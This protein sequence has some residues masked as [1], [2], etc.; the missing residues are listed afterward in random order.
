MN[1]NTLLSL[2]IF[3]SIIYAVYLT[4]LNTDP[5][6]GIYVTDNDHGDFYVTALHDLGWGWHNGIQH[7]D[8]IVLIDGE[9]PEHNHI[10]TTH[11]R[12]EQVKTLT[13]NQNGTDMT[14]QIDYSS[15]LA[16]QGIIYFLIPFLYFLMS[17]LL[18]LTLYKNYKN[19]SSLT[20][21]YFML[22]LAIGYIGFS[23]SMKLSSV[24][25]IT[26]DFTLLT[27]PILFLHFIYHFMK[28]KGAIW[29]SKN[30]LYILY[31][32]AMIVFFLVTFEPIDLPIKEVLLITFVCFLTVIGICLTKSFIV[33]KNKNNLLKTTYSWIFK[34][35]VIAIAPYTL[36]YAIPHIVLGSAL[37]RGEIAILFIFTLP[38]CFLFL[39]TTGR[40]YLIRI[41]IKQFTYY[42]ILSFVFTLFICG[43]Y[44]ALSEEPFQI[45]TLGIFFVFTFL[46]TFSSFFFKNY[47]DRLLRSSLFVERDYYQK[48]IYR[49]SEALKHENSVDGVLKDFQREV[50]D[51]LSANHLDFYPIDK[52]RKENDDKDLNESY[53]KLSRKLQRSTLRIGKI[54]LLGSTFSIPIGEKDE[55]YIVLFATL[56]N[57]RN[58]NVEEQDWLS[59]LAYHASV[60]LENMIKIE[61]L[62]T[63][64][65]KNQSSD[66][67]WINRLIFKWSEEERKKLANDIH[68]SFLQDI[69]ILKRKMEDVK[70]KTKEAEVTEQL[71]EMNEDIEDIIFQMRE[72][73]QEIAPPLLIEFGLKATLTEL[74]NKFN[75]RS[76]SLLSIQIDDSFDEQA[77]NLDYKRILFRTVQ[78][79]LNNAAKHSRASE[80]RVTLGVNNH[81]LEL[82]YVDNG[83]G[84]KL[85]NMRSTENKMGLVGMKERIQSFN[86][87]VTF[88][89]EPGKGLTV[90]ANIPI[91]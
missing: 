62:L 2:F 32:I 30:V 25:L 33:L 55:H 40:L 66:S 84:M 52:Y 49:F 5:Y 6:I 91:K 70:S 64:L 57:V 15:V 3:F 77:L 50:T 27:A 86:G 28:E 34:T 39:L 36:L 88:N 63:Q 48:S 68:D 26:G 71:F 22:V 35:L 85:I 72:T 56:N 44:Y 80:V 16:Q 9:Q 46:F 51:V 17:L 45:T 12:I 13:V 83:I 58:L 67:H 79:L 18:S 74:Q 38:I 61:D 4:Q 78:E 29:F 43:L 69:I 20:L 37:I 76:N 42:A 41:H 54:T 47:L 60:S 81:H 21:I 10:V 24:G 73:C 82:A 7:G 87:T 19:N 14:F 75:L 23:L 31:G 8:L 89:S 59:T 1:K 11:G 90:I 53:Q 65:K